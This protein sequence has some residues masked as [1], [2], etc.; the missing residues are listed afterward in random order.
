V[1]R[2]C[3]DPA[4]ARPRLRLESGSA[5]EHQERGRPCPPA[6][7]HA[8]RRQPGEG[9]S[10]GRLSTEG[11][12]PS[13][14]TPEGGV[15]EEDA[16]GAGAAAG[17]PAAPADVPE[18]ATAA[19]LEERCG[20][21]QARC[22]SLCVRALLQRGG[23]VAQ[24]RGG[25]KPWRARVQACISPSPGAP[26][27]SV[28]PA[29]RRPDDRLGAPAADA[30]RACERAEARAGRPVRAGAAGPC[31]RGLCGPAGAGPRS[32]RPLGAAAAAVH[33]GQ[34]AAPGAR[35]RTVGPCTPLPLCTSSCM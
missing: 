33:L 12:T 23:A 27:A 31:I 22:A 7:R 13:R 6:V 4:E 35:R 19:A 3:R 34:R 10:E 11:L 18:A 17:A 30:A 9:W 21:A 16:F 26:A 5:P 14:A 15:P 20:A 1:C 2:S 32:G 25:Q 8:Q 24:A 28:M 29:W